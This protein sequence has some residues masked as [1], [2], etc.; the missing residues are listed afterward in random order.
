MGAPRHAYVWLIVGLLAASQS[1]NIIRLGDA[2]PVAITAWRVILSCLILTPFALPHVKALGALTRRDWLLLGLAGLALALHW[3]TW[4][5]AVQLSTVANAAVFFSINP[6]LL[7]GAGY[8][9]FGER[10]GPRLLLSIGLGVGGVAVLG[11]GDFK[12]A[13]QYLAG[14]LWAIASAVL[15]AV[16]FSIGKTL[17]RKLPSQVYVVGVYGASGV[18]AV[19]TLLVMQLPLVE[20]SGQTWLCFALMALLPTAL[21][22]T[23]LNHALGYFDVGRLSVT[24]LSEPVLAGLVAYFAWHEKVGWQTGV[25]YG[26]ICLSVLVLVTERQPEK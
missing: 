2:H 13:P 14:D 23:G 26:L 21:G 16:Y 20:Y 6:V 1:G 4:V 18:V 24:T 19:A 15:F 5:A 25:G 9:I 11:A 8:F 10:V 17:R 7:A 22:H 3:F 12:L